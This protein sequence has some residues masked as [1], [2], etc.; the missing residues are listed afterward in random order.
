MQR[1]QHVQSP[2]VGRTKRRLVWL[3]DGEE[4]VGGG[5]QLERQAGVE[6][7]SSGGCT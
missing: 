3:D 6:L 2:V 7:Q 1:E 4:E 5:M